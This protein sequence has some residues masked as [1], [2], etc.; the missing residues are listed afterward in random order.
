M[1]GYGFIV[2]KF[3]HFTCVGVGSLEKGKKICCLALF[4]SRGQN[5]KPLLP[6]IWPQN[7]SNSEKNDE[8]IKGLNSRCLEIRGGQ[9]VHPGISWSSFSGSW[10]LLLHEP[11][12][13]LTGGVPLLAGLPDARL[14]LQQKVSGAPS[15]AQQLCRGSGPPPASALLLSPPAPQSGPALPCSLSC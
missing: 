9:V 2:P 1:K 4:F 3:N 15:P 12:L 7:G 5:T 11:G 13:C 14:H 8:I 10:F 6:Q